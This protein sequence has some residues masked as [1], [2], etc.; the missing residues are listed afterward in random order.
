MK[1]SNGL[2]RKKGFSTTLKSKKTLQGSGL[3]QR[4]NV[5]KGA[6]LKSRSK[7]RDLALKEYSKL[8][9]EFLRNNP[10]CAFCYLSTPSGFQSEPLHGAT[11]IHHSKG[12][13]GRLLCDVRWFI[14]TCGH[15]HSW[16][17]ANH[18]ECRTLFW[19]DIPLMC[20][21]SEFNTFPE[22]I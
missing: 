3:K 8:R 21:P 19:N 15:H 4:T 6:S 1:R 9:L 10:A 17:E 18:R 12:K 11:Q 13:V 7:K 16:I 22:I 14:P 2:K 5:G 20:Q